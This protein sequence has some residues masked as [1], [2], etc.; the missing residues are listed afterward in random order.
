MERKERKEMR[1]K[2]IWN[3]DVVG[4][5]LFV[6]ICTCIYVCCSYLCICIYV[7]CSYLCICMFVCVFVC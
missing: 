7:C 1:K 3:D 5:C 4:V 6:Y 2:G